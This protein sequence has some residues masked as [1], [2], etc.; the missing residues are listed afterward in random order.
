MITDWTWTP[1]ALLTL[2][3][4]ALLTA[5]CPSSDDD[6]MGAGGT[7]GET[8]APET[9]GETPDTDAD[10][11]DTDGDEPDTDGDE[12]L[13]ADCSCYNPAVDVGLD[14]DESCL[15]VEEALPG[16]AIDEPP[17]DAIIEGE[18]ESG[19]EASVGPE[20][21]IT[22]LAERL[23]AGESPA[24][25]LGWESFMGGD[26]TRYVPLGDG[27]Y[28]AF[29]CGFFDN[30]PAYQSVSTYQLADADYFTACMDDNP[31]DAVALYECL[32]NGLTKADE[33]M[34]ACE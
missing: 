3:A 24:F 4:A 9:E 25:I 22:C 13:P 8:E 28:V 27:R 11:P 32:E 34:L 29:N 18:G 30:P 17:C 15:S 5:G 26:T 23:A 19:G 6:P 12:P 1:Y 14:F 2:G 16:C 10:E 31:E 20:E 7:D 33:P 21:A